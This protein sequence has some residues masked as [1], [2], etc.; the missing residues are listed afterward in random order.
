MNC[1]EQAVG[2]VTQLP[3]GW[4]EENQSQQMAIKPIDSNGDG[5]PEEPAPWMPLW[6]QLKRAIGWIVSGLAISMG[7]AFWFEFL[8]KLVN[9]RNTGKRPDDRS[10]T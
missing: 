6:N 1:I 5:K 3:L 2:D 10:A 4:G 8:S 7:A 9:V